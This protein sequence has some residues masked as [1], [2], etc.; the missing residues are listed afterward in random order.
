MS[1]KG[2]DRKLVIETAIWLFV[3]G[4]F[5][6]FSFDI[7]DTTQTYLFGA[8]SWPRAIIGGMLLVTALQ[9][10]IG[11]FRPAPA[12]DT[13]TEEAKEGGFAGNLVLRLTVTLGTPL[14]YIFLLPRTGFY[15]TTPVFIAAYLYLL[16]ERR[17]VPLALITL[18]VYALVIGVFTSL[19]FVALPVGNWPGF[20][21]FSSW[22]ITVIR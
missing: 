7:L 5:Y 16:G 12:T 19:F 21:D 8:T 1:F 10:L 20:Y 9:F 11:Y 17:V 6:Y 15:L 22:F 4:F 14:L 3:A 2:I 13:V 18:F